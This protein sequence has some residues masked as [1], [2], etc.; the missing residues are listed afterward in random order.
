MVR[1]FGTGMVEGEGILGGLDIVNGRPEASVSWVNL[2][3]G[4]PGLH[5]GK[6]RF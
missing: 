3:G 1:G 4:Q 2:G 6:G 5:W